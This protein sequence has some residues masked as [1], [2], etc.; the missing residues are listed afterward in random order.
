MTRMRRLCTSHVDAEEET[1]MTRKG[2]EAGME[3]KIPG[4]ESFLRSASS[5]INVTNNANDAGRRLLHKV[6]DDEDGL[7]PAEIEAPR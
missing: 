6:I 1:R 2:R 5:A 3:K 4:R 7:N